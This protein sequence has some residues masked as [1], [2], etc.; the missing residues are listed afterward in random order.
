MIR[1][2]VFLQTVVVS[3]VLITISGCWRRPYQTPVWEELFPNCDAYVQPLTL[4]AEEGASD[5]A[6]V[7]SPK[8]ETKEGVDTQAVKEGVEKI[9]KERRMMKRIN[10]PTDWQSLGRSYTNGQWTPT[11]Q[12]IQVD[13]SI[14]TREWTA[15]NET[16]TS[17]ANQALPL[18][19]QD[20]INFGLPFL[21][22]A[23][24]SDSALYRFKFGI[25]TLGTV[26]DK[27]VRPLY[28]G[29]GTVAFKK[30]QAGPELEA[31][32][33]IAVAEMAGPV[34]EQVSQWGIEILRASMIGG[35]VYDDKKIQVDMD[36]NFTSGMSAEVEKQKNI[37]QVT[38]NT[39]TVQTADAE[40]K[41]AEAIYAARKAQEQ[42]VLLESAVIRAKASLE[43]AKAWDGVLPRI[44]PADMVDL[45]PVMTQTNLK[46][47][48]VPATAPAVAVPPPAEK[49]EPAKPAS[50]TP[51]AEAPKP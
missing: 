10:I 23:R 16:G 4:G 5:K 43:A 18:E 38:R 40:K 6:V 48:E 27:N 14:V 9:R 44:M 19:S 17:T 42:R 50:A 37:A 22:M 47:V 24:I 30:W 51:V 25:Q 2:R 35:P 13:R 3:L 20:S 34:K 36:K 32:K 33:V 12:V 46:P 28:I 1:S 21:V 15:D 8:A 31:K 49:P 39:I 26:L 29:A 11:V 41:S 45:I 7:A